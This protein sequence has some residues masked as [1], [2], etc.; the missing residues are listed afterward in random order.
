MYEEKLKR[1]ALSQIN[2]RLKTIS[3][4]TATELWKSCDDNATAVW[5]A[6]IL[7]QLRHDAFYD[8]VGNALRQIE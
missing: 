3:W 7:S 1:C 6:A 5:S 8:W 4:G 2:L